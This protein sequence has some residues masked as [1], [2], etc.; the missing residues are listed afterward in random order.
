MTNDEMRPLDLESLVRQARAIRYCAQ[1]GTEEQ[2]VSMGFQPETAKAVILARECFRG[3]WWYAK[4][5]TR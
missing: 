3:D 2:L 4:Q 5:G 1:F